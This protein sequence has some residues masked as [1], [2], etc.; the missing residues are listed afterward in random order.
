MDN[1]TLFTCFLQAFTVKYGSHTILLFISL[2]AAV[3]YFGKENMSMRRMFHT[4]LCLLLALLMIVSFAACGKKAEPEA[5]PE[6]T[7]ASTP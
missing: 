2:R 5:T 1:S 4:C 7:P 6:P 3:N